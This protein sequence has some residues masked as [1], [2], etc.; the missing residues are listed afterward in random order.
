M[1]LEH[2]SHNLRG[3]SGFEF[4]VQGLGLRFQVEGLEFGG[5]GLGFLF[6]GGSG[7]VE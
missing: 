1:E 6:P 4:K 5:K 7:P 3:G 2:F